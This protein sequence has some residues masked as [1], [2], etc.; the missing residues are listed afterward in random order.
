MMLREGTLLAGRTSP[1]LGA[2]I[3]ALPRTSRSKSFMIPYCCNTCFIDQHWNLDG[4]ARQT[5]TV[6]RVPLVGASL[7]RRSDAW[8][9]LLSV[10]VA[11][12][13]RARAMIPTRRDRPGKRPKGI[14]GGRCGFRCT[15]TFLRKRALVS[16]V[17]PCCSA[18]WMAREGCSRRDSCWFRSVFV[19]HGEALPV[20]TGFMRWRAVSGLGGIILDLPHFDYCADYLGTL[21]VLLSFGLTVMVLEV[22]VMR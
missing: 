21:W 17:M 20:E 22:L 16:P 11:G 12:W 18:D 5:N 14:L 3:V 6:H 10:L 19:G 4:L 13:P 8:P 15:S 2:C 1:S 7:P 9:D